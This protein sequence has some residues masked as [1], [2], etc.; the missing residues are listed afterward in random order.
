MG[1]K[2]VL[3]CL[4]TVRCNRQPKYGNKGT[5]SLMAILKNY[6]DILEMNTEYPEIISRLKKSSILFEFLSQYI[7]DL[8]KEK[9]DEIA[10]TIFGSHIGAKS[11][12]SRKELMMLPSRT[13]LGKSELRCI[14]HFIVNYSDAE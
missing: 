11:I 8:S 13:S 10:A 6:P 9:T 5:G 12:A 4:G 3:D 1:N 14:D 7:E 2:K